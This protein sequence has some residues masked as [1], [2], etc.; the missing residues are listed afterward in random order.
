MKTADQLSRFDAACFGLFFYLQFYYFLVLI[1]DSWFLPPK[2]Y[3]L[4]IS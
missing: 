4:P 3:Y 1:L 2:P